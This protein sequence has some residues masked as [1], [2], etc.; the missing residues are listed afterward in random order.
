MPL[1]ADSQ[2]AVVA[3]RESDES[4]KVRVTAAA[5]ARRR[6][7]ADRDTD[8]LPKALKIARPTFTE[9]GSL[10]FCN[11]LR[12]GQEES[13]AKAAI[14]REYISQLERGEYS[15]TVDVLVRISAAVETRAWR[16]LRRVEE[17]I[18]RKT[19]GR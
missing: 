17:S 4:D 7:D 1:V 14:S 5:S 13:A 9:E 6:L 2:V 19:A 10:P 18:P 15:P 11:R 16:I 12:S 8:V 3:P